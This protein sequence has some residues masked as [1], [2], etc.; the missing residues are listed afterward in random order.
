MDYGELVDED[1]NPEH[2][3]IYSLMVKYFNNP[4][5][6]K[7]KNQNQFSMYACK[8]FGLLSKEHRYIIVFTYLDNEPIGTY[9]GLHNIRW[10]NLQTRTLT[11]NLPCT[12][13]SYIPTNESP[14]SVAI[15]RTETT[16]QSSTYL[17][18]TFPKISVTLLNNSKRSYQNE[19]TIVAALETYETI[20]S[21]I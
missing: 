20:I 13:H 9:I 21:F 6:T 4:T 1:Y 17:C 19:G 18:K 2:D 15:S 16:P 8:V 10:I 14:L 12:T 11:E 7:I 3:Y 5:M